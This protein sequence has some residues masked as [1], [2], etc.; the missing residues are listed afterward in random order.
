MEEILDVRS[1][2]VFS[3]AIINYG[4]YY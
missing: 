1:N 2:I 4:I 3:Q